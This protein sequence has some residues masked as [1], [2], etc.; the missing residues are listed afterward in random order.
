M[1]AKEVA[2]CSWVGGWNVWMSGLV[3]Q[4]Q[5]LS[6][7]AMPI[8]DVATTRDGFRAKHVHCESGPSDFLVSRG[9]RPGQTFH[10]IFFI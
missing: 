10:F 5:G 1:T 4:G 7:A 3:K 6:F 9:G 2:R 8:A